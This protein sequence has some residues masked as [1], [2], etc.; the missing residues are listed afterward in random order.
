M[1][2]D[3]IVAFK[4]TS[5]EYE[6]LDNFAKHLFKQKVIPKPTVNALAKSF[7]FVTANQFIMS[8]QQQQ[9]GAQNAPNLVGH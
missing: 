2:E 1:S 9:E 6:M 8:Q 5:E 4:L 3:K 7:T